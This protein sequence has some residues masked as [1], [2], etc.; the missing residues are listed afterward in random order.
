MRHRRMRRRTRAAGLV[1]LTA[2]GALAVPAGAQQETARS[3]AGPGY[4][5]FR[6][7]SESAI[8]LYA[9][10]TAGPVLLV[11]GMLQNPRTDYEEILGGAI[12][13]VFANDRAELLVAPAVASSNVGWYAQGYLLPAL[14]LGP[15]E[16]SGT[17]QF[18]LPFEEPGYRN[19]YVSPLN[20]WV[21]AL[22]FVDVGAAWY[23]A[24]EE[25]YGSFHA[26]GPALRVPIPNGA[27]IL[28][29]PIGFGDVKSE[30]RA[31]VRAG[32]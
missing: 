16:L 12:V 14:W 10:Y 11:V 27:V 15:L 25:G 28:E 26:L 19:A 17:F 1:A 9:G 3:E 30:L 7:A 6:F 13:T 5:E 31:T 24:F 8:A 21:D 22:P 20:A 29:H 2:L 32:F 4:L 23:A 18:G